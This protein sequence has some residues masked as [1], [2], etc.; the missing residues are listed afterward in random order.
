M[1]KVFKRTVAAGVAALAV[2]ALAACEPNSG[3]GGS[4][5]GCRP[6]DGSYGDYGDGGGG[7]GGSWGDSGGSWGGGGYGGDDLQVVGLTA[8]QR[9]ICFREDDPANARNI[10]TVRGLS[11]DTRL[12]GI[13]YRPATGALYGLG[14]RGGVYVLDD[15][16]GAATLRSRLNV[17]LSGSSFG[18]DFNPVV[19]RLRIISDNGQNLRA[20]VDTGATLV[21]GTLT[22]PGP[23]ATTATGVTGAG[24]TNNDS[25]PNTATTLYD[26]DSNLDQ[27]VIQSPA[28]SGQLAATGKLTV[29]T[30]ANIGF[31]VYSTV[32]NGSTVDVQALASLTVNGQVGIYE[33][34]LF[35]GR[36]RSQGTFSS[37]NRVTGIAIPLNQL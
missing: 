1:R 17:A 25:D 26:I 27:T 12:L 3:D 7:Y 16:N 29:D 35:N 20:N 13:D 24:Y 5:N 34:T 31:D 32:R 28:N 21:D 30:D 4:R 22:Y 15:R 10:G 36:A 11:G 8:D 19:D 2:F 37:N 14:D 23:P 33:V 18:V 9:L 6:G